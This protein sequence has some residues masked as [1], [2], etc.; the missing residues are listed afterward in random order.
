MA[1]LAVF[2]FSS[3]G[4]IFYTEA[5]FA[6]EPPS[7]CK[8]F[9]TIS[10]NNACIDG[11][12]GIDCSDYLI[13]HDEKH[14]DVCEEGSQAKESGATGEDSA[15]EAE[16]KEQISTNV[17]STERATDQL[18]KTVD[19]LAELNKDINKL[20]GG[21][22]TEADSVEDNHYG[23]YVNGAGK[24]QPIRVH[25]ASGD[26]NPA[27]IFLNGGGWVVD[28]GTGGKVS[29][30][31]NERGY[32]TFE[33]TYRLGSSG[34]YY[35]YEDVM[36]AIR[37]IRNNANMYGI[38]PNRIAVWGD[39]AGGSLAMRSASS[40]KTGAKAAVGWSAPTNA[41]TAIFKG[42]EAFAIGMYHSTC[43]PTDLDGLIDV[44]G[45]LNGGSGLNPKAD[46][47]G[48]IGN[49]NFDSIVNGDSLGTVTDVLS[50]AR[51]AQTNSLSSETISRQIEDTQTGSTSGGISGEQSENTRRLT[52]KKFL[53]CI[54]NFSSAS[55][56]LFASA[57]SPPTFL[58]GY[59]QDW[60]I[61]PGQAYQM[62]DK[63]RTL[64]V[65]SDALILP[66]K[67]HLG[68][69]EEMVKP[70]LDFLDKFLHPANAPQ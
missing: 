23:Q 15:T 41:Y 17:D 66:G 2:T 58:A 59:E 60:L 31:A 32:T 65:P 50:L 57:L 25:K 40:G 68:Y 29:P 51:K 52:S 49:N 19:Q 12:N 10:E 47:G 35:Q 63:L 6:Q 27:I 28:D 7:F 37:H 56:A 5:A 70:S 55:P 26:S 45:Q 38:D 64:G 42:P 14:R 22:G 8:Q 69:E 44:T 1:L 54:D 11:F 16:I 67:K 36:R 62:R 4:A 3:S 34:I 33:A 18:E 53:E 39:S 46:Y 24:L 61:D 48:G 9:K 13:T 21:D 43:V 30:K 20:N